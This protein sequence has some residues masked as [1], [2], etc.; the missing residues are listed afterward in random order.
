MKFFCHLFS[1]GIDFH[2]DQNSQQENKYVSKQNGITFQ[3]W[4]VVEN[5]RCFYPD[6]IFFT[7]KIMKVNSSS[8]K[9]K[10]DTS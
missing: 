10:S 9:T 5:S 3:L 4:T 2:Y 7:G 6:Y 8:H 1:S